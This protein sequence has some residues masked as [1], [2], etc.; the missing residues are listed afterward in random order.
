MNGNY[1]ENIQDNEGIKDSCSHFLDFLF[2]SWAHIAISRAN[3]GY[4]DHFT[5]RLT[6]VGGILLIVVVHQS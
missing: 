2:E 3:K 5:F 6:T 1:R 4:L